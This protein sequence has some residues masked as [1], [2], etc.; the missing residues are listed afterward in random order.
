MYMNSNSYHP[1]S[2]RSTPSFL[3]IDSERGIHR[4]RPSYFREGGCQATRWDAV[5]LSFLLSRKNEMCNLKFNRCIHPLPGESDRR[6]RRDS[7]EPKLACPNCAPM[8]LNVEL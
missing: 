8:A 3:F 2:E 5:V 7:L 4:P 1:S 6:S